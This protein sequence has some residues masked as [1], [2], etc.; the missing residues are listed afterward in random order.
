VLGRIVEER[1]QRFLVVNH[2]GDR[3]GPL[4]PVVAD[5]RLDGPLGVRPVLGLGDLVEGAARAGLHALGQGV[6]NVG[7][8]MKP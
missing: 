1:Q 3:L 2:L 8:L 6:Q 4:G 7:H 5:Q